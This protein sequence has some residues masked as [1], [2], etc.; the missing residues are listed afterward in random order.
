M[1]CFHDL[2]RGIN[3]DDFEI[4]FRTNSYDIKLAESILINRFNPSLNN[5]VS[6]VPLNIAN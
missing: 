4:I 3:R 6:S 5:S 1:I 2:F